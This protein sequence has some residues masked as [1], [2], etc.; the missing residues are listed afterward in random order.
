VVH[1]DERNRVKVAAYQAPLLPSGSMEAIGLIETQIQ[2]CENEGISI[3][4]CPEAVLGGLADY[5][6]DPVRIAMP[7]DRLPSVL[8]PLAS[9]TVTTIVGFTEVDGDRLYNTAAVF[10]QGVVKGVYRKLH[11][12]I[13]RS[14][15][16]PGSKAPVFQIGS[17]TFGI[18]ICND[19]NYS[20]PA[21]RMA[22]QGATALFIPTNCGLP[23]NRS[24]AGLV[25]E[26]REVDTA[27]AIEN[28]LWIIRADVAGS[29]DQ[30]LSYGSSGIVDPDG[31]VVRTTRQ[32]S[33]DFLVAD[34]DV[35]PRSIPTND[36]YSAI[37]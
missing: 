32:L 29:N 10:H 25:A 37:R 17:L 35:A 6:N 5:T 14:V 2:R 27:T 7:I 31:T 20:E 3:L 4:C 36:G 23:L 11:P 26:A 22:A 21:R 30:L 12:A 8:A 13:R 24:T 15:Y 18:V 19:S 34:V 28:R 16:S 33:D 1:E 9:D